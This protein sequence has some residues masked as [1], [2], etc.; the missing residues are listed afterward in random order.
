MKTVINSTPIAFHRSQIV[1]A[2]ISYL[3]LDYIVADKM[4]QYKQ[5][6]L[7]TAVLRSSLPITT[8]SSRVIRRADKSIEDITLPHRT[9]SHPQ[10]DTTEV[11]N[12]GIKDSACTHRPSDFSIKKSHP[13]YWLHYYCLGLLI[14]STISCWSIN[15]TPAY[16][17][18]I[19][20]THFI[21]CI[22]LFVLSHCF[23]AL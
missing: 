17:T 4:K 21:I 10:T 5:E 11:W 3:Q 18:Q 22:S 13:N 19:S 6:I 14:L 1:V 16:L 12:R 15:T 20:L 2:T 23:L 7:D 9:R 8:Y